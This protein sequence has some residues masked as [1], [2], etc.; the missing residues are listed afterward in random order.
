MAIDNG[1]GRSEA[2]RKETVFLFRKL[3]G[4]EARH[5]GIAV[6]QHLLGIDF[7]PFGRGR[8]A[9]CEVWLGCD[10]SI[11]RDALWRGSEGVE[12]NPRGRQYV[13]VPLVRVAIEHDVRETEPAG[14]FQHDIGIA[15]RLAD[16]F[17]HGR[18]ELDLA[19]AL[20]AGIEA[21][22][23]PFALP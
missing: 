18:A 1:L 9:V 7:Q 20:K 2:E 17:D 12:T 15:L 23:Q 13:G 11:Q 8:E 6:I 5:R 22:P 4:I 16:R 3:C 10:L 14:Q 21:V 19:H